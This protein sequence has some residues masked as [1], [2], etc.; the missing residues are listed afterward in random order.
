MVY[1][2]QNLHQNRGRTYHLSFRVVSELVVDSSVKMNSE[3]RHS[4][5]RLVDFDEVSRVRILRR[6]LC[7]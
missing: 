2:E 4:E 6:S 7:S 3:S 5:D 1:F